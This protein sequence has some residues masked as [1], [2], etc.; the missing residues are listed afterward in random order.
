[1]SLG[2]LPVTRHLGKE[3][4]ERAMASQTVLAHS[5][6]GDLCLLDSTHSTQIQ[7]QP[8]PNEGK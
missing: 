3:S 4:R 7:R 2:A 5:R 8:D 1:M 6:S